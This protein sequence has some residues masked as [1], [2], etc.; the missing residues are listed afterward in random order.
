[1]CT[2]GIFDTVKVFW[3]S[4]LWPLDAAKACLNVAG[5]NFV[6]KRLFFCLKTGSS[7]ALMTEI[8]NKKTNS[9]GTPVPGMQGKYFTTD[10]YAEKDGMC[11]YIDDV[12]AYSRKGPDDSHNDV[13]KRHAALVT[14]FVTKR[15][16]TEI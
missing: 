13:M 5:Q 2:Q 16:R 1:M 14:R 10:L 15:R 9:D 4:K 7:H 6:L 8:I 3:T 11:L 12:V